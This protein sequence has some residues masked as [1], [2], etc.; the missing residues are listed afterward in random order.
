MLL[1]VHPSSESTAFTFESSLVASIRS[2]FLAYGDV[3]R[4]WTRSLCRRM[5][6]TSA[7]RDP[8]ALSRDG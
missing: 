1:R 8:Q 3:F 4:R 6:R 7:K 5:A 2:S